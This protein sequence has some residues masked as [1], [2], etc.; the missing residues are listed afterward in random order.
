MAVMVFYLGRTLIRFIA[1]PGASLRVT[2]EIEK[3]FA[4]YSVRMLASDV[5]S[6]VKVATILTLAPA[7]RDSLPTL[8]R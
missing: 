8:W 2:A 1:F 7:L 6:L 5:R 4:K 3:E